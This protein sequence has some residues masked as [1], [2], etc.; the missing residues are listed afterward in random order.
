MK[1]FIVLFIIILPFTPIFIG[2]EQ[3]EEKYIQ[4]GDV[5]IEFLFNENKIWAQNKND[6]YVIA[7]FWRWNGTETVGE[8]FCRIRLAPVGHWSGWD[9]DDKEAYFSHGEEV[10]IVIS[11]YDLSWEDFWDWDSW[12]YREELGRKVV[13]L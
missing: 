6:A 4:V 12:K 8:A 2:C 9:N 5:Y 11:K 7:E 10:L 3:E 1:R 13:R